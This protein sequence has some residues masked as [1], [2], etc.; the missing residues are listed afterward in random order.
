MPEQTPF[1]QLPPG[2]WA[3]PPIE[4]PAP[5][6]ADPYPAGPV[7]EDRPAEVPV[8]AR[9]VPPGLPSPRRQPVPARPVSPLRAVAGAAVAVAGVLLGIGALLWA[10]DAPTGSPALQQTQAQ[11]SQLAPSPTA[12]AVTTTPA[13]AL[14]HPAHRPAA[15]PRVPLTV[16]NNSTRTGLAARAAGR[17][18]SAGWPVRLVGAFRG[19]LTQT[20]VYFAPGQKP[21][22]LALQKAFPGITRVLPRFAGL[23]GSGLTVV[24]TRTYPA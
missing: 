14:T 8:A 3:F 19:R 17:F 4:P 6:A 2:D 12:S 7:T 15:A 22:A 13:P 23:P 24:L 11:S 1:G 18:V 10:T 20:T 21:S 9:L 5:P 16:L